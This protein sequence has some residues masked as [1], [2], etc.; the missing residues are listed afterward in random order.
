MVEENAQRPAENDATAPAKTNP[1][2]FIIDHFG[3]QLT[4]NL[5]T[6]EYAENDRLAV[7]L[8][9][10]EEL[11][12]VVSVNVPEVD[13]DTEEF[14]FKTYTENEGLFEE[15]LRLGVIRATGRCC[16][17]GP[18]C[19]LQVVHNRYQRIDELD[20]DFPDDAYTSDCN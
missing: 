3:R 5:V 6:A 12:A 13:L 9:Q 11:Y 1:S 14:V 4:V 8:F 18:I 15:L 16:A 7:Q 20:R 2:T 19:V 10:D 17:V